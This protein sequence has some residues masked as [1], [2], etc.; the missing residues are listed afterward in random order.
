MSTTFQNQACQ[1]KL[2]MGS[3]DIPVSSLNIFD[4]LAIL[5]LIPIFDKFLYSFIERKTKR[6]VLFLQII[7]INL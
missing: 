5:I 4:S 7:I 2:N 3:I 1:M 6:K